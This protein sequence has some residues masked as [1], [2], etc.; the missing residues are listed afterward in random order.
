MS[1]TVAH[2]IFWSIEIHLVFQIFAGHHSTLSLQRS[3][4]IQPFSP[5]TSGN[6]AQAF[7][8]NSACPVSHRSTQLPQIPGLTH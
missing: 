4:R 1:F 8:L 6:I 2:L 7:F 5:K 3:T